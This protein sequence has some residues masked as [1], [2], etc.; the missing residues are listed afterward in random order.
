MISFGRIFT[1]EMETIYI[2]QIT[3]FLYPQY[4]TV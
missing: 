2:N 4:I 1:L 3:K